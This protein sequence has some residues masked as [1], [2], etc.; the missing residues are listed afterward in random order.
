[1]VEA[2]SFEA[3]SDRLNFQRLGLE[4]S[5]DTF[6]STDPESTDSSASATAG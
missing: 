3:L 4:D 1:M 5:E 6:E 2:F